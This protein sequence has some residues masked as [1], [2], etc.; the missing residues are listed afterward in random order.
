[1][2]RPQAIPA[3][4]YPLRLSDENIRGAAQVIYLLPEE[5]IFLLNFNLSIKALEKHAYLTRI[6]DAQ[7]R[8]IWDVGNVKPAGQYETFTIACFGASFKEGSYVLVVTEINPSGR[9]TSRKF[10]YP[11]IL[12]K[13]K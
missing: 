6:Y 3:Q 12:K 1:M 13:K 2:Q 11:F 10:F 4:G 8:L 5:N 7:K 9:P